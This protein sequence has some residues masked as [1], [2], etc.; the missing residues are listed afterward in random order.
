[1]PK[2]NPGLGE[3]SLRKDKTWFLKVPEEMTRWGCSLWVLNKYACSISSDFKW[4]ITDDSVTQSLSIRG[5][6]LWKRNV[7]ISRIHNLCSELYNLNTQ[8]Q[9]RWAAASPAHTAHSSDTIFLAVT[10]V[11]PT[12]LWKFPRTHFVLHSNSNETSRKQ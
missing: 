6:T 5:L 11:R 7:K 10:K 8:G 3:G 1:M 4:V 2:C 12:F 9:W